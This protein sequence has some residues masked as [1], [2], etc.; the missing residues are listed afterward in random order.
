MHVLETVGVIGV[1]Y[2]V[3]RIIGKRLLPP[4]TGNLM[5]AI[6]L[7]SSVL[8]E[9]I[10]PIS[11]KL[12]LIL[13]GSIPTAKLL[14]PVPQEELSEDVKQEKEEELVPE[15]TAAGAEDAAKSFINFVEEL[16]AGVGER[17]DDD[18][19]KIV[20]AGLKEDKGKKKKKHKK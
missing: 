14:E 18:I 20:P 2:F 6:I 19:E 9:M 5:L 13:S 10:G 4:E 7:S 3:I 15:E 16:N 17:D 8:Y 12:A 11:A 1:S